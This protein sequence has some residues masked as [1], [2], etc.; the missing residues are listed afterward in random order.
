MRGGESA[1]ITSADC[2]V[3]ERIGRT[4][5]VTEFF[6][7]AHIIIADPTIRSALCRWKDAGSDFASW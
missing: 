7:L 2:R 6:V 1:L 3:V 4:L 5:Y